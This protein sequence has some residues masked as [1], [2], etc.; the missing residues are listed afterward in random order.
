MKLRTPVYCCLGLAMIVLL[1]SAHVSYYFQNAFAAYYTGVASITTKNPVIT[2]TVPTVNQHEINLKL[3]YAHFLSIPTSTTNKA[4]QVKVIVN[5]TVSIS[6]APILNK[7]INAVMKVYA[8][9]GTLIKISSFP[10]GFVAT[11]F[12]SEQLATTVKD[13]KIQQLTAVV[14]FMTEDKLQ[15]L[16]NPITVKLVF[17]QKIGSRL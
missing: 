10:K 13:N 15:P 1:T 17:G 4:H 5:Y 9:N 3:H 8:L 6:N 7:T 12:A 14:Q 2:S 16:S 11:R